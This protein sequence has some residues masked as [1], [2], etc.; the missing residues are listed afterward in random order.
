M[1]LHACSQRLYLWSPTSS[2]CH[3][4]HSRFCVDRACLKKTKQCAG[5]DRTTKTENGPSGPSNLWT[6]GMCVVGVLS[7]FAIDLEAHYKF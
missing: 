2:S 6:N 1:Y 5:V 3:K 7:V 4:H